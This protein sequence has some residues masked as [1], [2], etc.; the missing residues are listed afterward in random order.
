MEAETWTLDQDLLPCYVDGHF[1][2][3]PACLQMKAG[4]GSERPIYIM[5]EEWPKNCGD[6]LWV[7]SVIILLHGAGQQRIQIRRN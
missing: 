2:H 4:N 7:K 3:V 5:H 6:L 1:L